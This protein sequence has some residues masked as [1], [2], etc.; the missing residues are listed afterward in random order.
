MY[1]FEDDHE[2]SSRYKRTMYDA[3]KQAQA[4]E[5]EPATQHIPD[6]GRSTITLPDDPTLEDLP[7]QP[8][9][10]ATVPVQK[11]TPAATAA[12]IVACIGVFLTALDQTVVVTALPQVITDLNIPLT[13]LDHAA[14][15]ISAYLLGFVVAM[16]L[17]GRVSDIYGAGASFSCVWPSLALVLYFVVSPPFWAK[18]YPC[19][20]WP[21]CIL[22][23]PRQG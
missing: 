18:I 9:Q 11:S 4:D 20:S 23:F 12:I 6:G 21:R 19:N 17:M 13:Q 3:S 2:T 8:R 15:I 16:P 7:T 1:T 22:I 14:W 10:E 5:Q